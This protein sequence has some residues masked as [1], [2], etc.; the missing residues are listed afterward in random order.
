M[1]MIVGGDESRFANVLGCFALAQ[2]SAT[3]L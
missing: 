3:L 2:V 1:E